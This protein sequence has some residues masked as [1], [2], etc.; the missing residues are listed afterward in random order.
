M[1]RAGRGE[2]HERDDL[3]C[4]PPIGRGN[5]STNRPMVGSSRPAFSWGVSTAAGAT[6]F[7][8]MPEP[9]TTTVRIVTK[10]RNQVMMAKVQLDSVESRG[11]EQ[12]TA[13]GELL[14]GSHRAQGSRAGDFRTW[15]A[16]ARARTIDT[17]R[18]QRRAPTPGARWS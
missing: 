12:P 7:N 9:V 4:Q 2:V 10:R 18:S 6:T 5:F 8:V 13:R 1:V 14:D 3:G 15:P 17:V 11:S 16:T